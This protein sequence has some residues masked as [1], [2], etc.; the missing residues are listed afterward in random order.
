[1]LSFP[2]RIRY[3]GTIEPSESAGPEAWLQAAT[4]GLM[5]LSSFFLEIITRGLLFKQLP[6]N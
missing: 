4:T 1:M 3:I 6:Y 5:H 2:N